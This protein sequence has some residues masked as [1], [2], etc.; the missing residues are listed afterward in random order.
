MSKVLLRGIDLK[1]ELDWGREGR[2]IVGVDEVGRG[3]IAGPVVAAAVVFDFAGLVQEGRLRRRDA[4]PGRL[5]LRGEADRWVVI[6]DGIEQEIVVRDSKKMTRE[7]RRRSAEVLRKLALSF[8]VGEV[9]SKRIDEINILQATFEAMRIA[10]D[11][12]V[13]RLDQ[14]KDWTLVLVDGNRPIPNLEFNQQAEVK[15]DGRF[16]SIAAA[17]IIAKEYRDQIMERIAIDHPNYKFQ[18]H[19]G[20][21]TGEHYEAISK[22][23]LTPEHRKTFGL[24]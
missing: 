23:G 14:S 7:Q 10:I 20:Y 19:K 8:A 21:G 2:V 9:D 13:D 5:Y 6:V 16:F 24:D 4:P 17:S 1:A 12:A 11:G 18:K 22:F 3:C 15:G